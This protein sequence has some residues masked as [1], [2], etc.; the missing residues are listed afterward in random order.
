VRRKR[1]TKA[2]LI[3]PP[4]T[5]PPATTIVTTAATSAPKASEEQHISGRG[6]LLVIIGLAGTGILALIVRAPSEVP[7][8]RN[9]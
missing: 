1:L 9:P 2:S 6:L 3:A 8:I 4:A 7:S 5:I